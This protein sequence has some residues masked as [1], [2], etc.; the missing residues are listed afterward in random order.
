MM[1][2]DYTIDVR[3]R[4]LVRMGSRLVNPAHVVS[5]EELHTYEL[6]TMSDGSTFEAPKGSGVKIE[7]ADMRWPRAIVEAIEWTEHR[8]SGGVAEL[9]G[10]FAERRAILKKLRELAE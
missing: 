6:V 8:N 5:V 1:A 4:V 3:A 2:K 7:V 10:A 9:A